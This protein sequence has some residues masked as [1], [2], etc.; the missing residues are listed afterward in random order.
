MGSRLVG[1]QKNVV[2]EAAF[3]K[4]VHYLEENDEEQITVNCLIAKMKDYLADAEKPFTFPH[5]KARLSEYF[6]NYIVFSEV[7]GKANVVTFTDIQHLTY[8]STNFLFPKVT[9]W[10]KRNGR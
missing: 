1:R 5:M 3:M 4:V 10:R 8:I 9:I 6:G 2:K 7:N